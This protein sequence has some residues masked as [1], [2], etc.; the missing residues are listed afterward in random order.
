M[1][2]RLDYFQA[3]PNSGDRLRFQV[4]SLVKGLDH[5]KGETDLEHTKGIGHDLGSP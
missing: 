4:L 5:D 2:A 1:P 3:F